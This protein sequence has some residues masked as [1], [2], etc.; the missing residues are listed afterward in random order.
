MIGLATGG[1]ARRRRYRSLVALTAGSLLAV[2]ACGS[3]GTSST[4]ATT[5]AAA[6][7]A[8]S[9]A[10]SVKTIAFAVHNQGSG[11]FVELAQRFVDYGK[12][13]GIDVKIY[14]NNGDAATAISNA[15]L[16]V[17]AKPDVIVE[18]PP[19][20]DATARITSVFKGSGIPCIAVNI[21]VEGCPFFN[22]SQETFAKLQAEQFAKLMKDKGWDGTN[23]TVVIGQGATFGATV[24]I[25]VT[26]FYE[27]ISKAV[28]G[29]TVVTADKI[30]PQT[31]T[32]SPQGIQ[33][34]TSVDASK[35]FTAMNEALQTIPK[36][37]NIIAY[38]I[39]D[40]DIVG[41]NRALKTAGRADKSMVAGFGC[42]AHALE[43]LRTNP[44]WVGES[45]G[46]FTHWGEFLVA[47]AVAVKN[48]AQTPETTFS[49]MVVL[50]KE[51]VDQYFAPGDTN[52]KKFAPL[53]DVSK[54]LGDTGILQKF[55]NVEGL[56]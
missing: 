22:Q 25:A 24:N 3:G 17:Q 15:Q 52:P 4:S 21:P 16:M 46:W 27:E 41:I 12:Q 19:V 2:T 30:T 13:V 48:G 32:I 43:G 20:A 51:N 55:G 9:A 40:D 45:C 35:A 28:P 1:S 29:M 11:Q 38:A 6:G 34:D 36:D 37:R 53:P 10:A 39:S 33:I 8:S 49:P 23:T 44:A 31:T 50:N 26:K 7:G 47:M 18:F 14:N 54:Y 56:S 42:D 5:S